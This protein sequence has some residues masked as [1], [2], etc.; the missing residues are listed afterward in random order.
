LDDFLLSQNVHDWNVHHL[1]CL[2]SLP[3]FF[4][5]SMDLARKHCSAGNLTEETSR[6]QHC[7]CSGGRRTLAVGSELLCVAL[8]GLELSILLGLH[9]V[10][11]VTTFPALADL[12]AGGA[13]S[14]SYLN[15]FRP[16]PAAPAK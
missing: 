13:P 6:H 5:D 9:R 11:S 2:I 10:M 12:L 15:L 8:R 14:K 16:Q 4:F 7:N 1:H 3:P